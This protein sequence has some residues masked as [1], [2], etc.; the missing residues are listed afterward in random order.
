MVTLSKTTP[1]LNESALKRVKELICDPSR[2]RVAVE[3]CECG[4]TI[5]DAG[6][7]AKGGLLAGEIVAEICLTGCGTARI[8]PV[9]YGEQTLLSVF[10]AVDCPALLALDTQYKDLQDGSESFSANG[11]GPANVLAMENSELLKRLQIEE[12]S[13]VAVMALETERAP[14][15]SLIRQIA[16]KCVVSFDDLFVVIFSRNSLTGAVKASGQIVS[17]GLRRLMQAG[18]D[19][20]LVKYAWGYAPIATLHKNPAEFSERTKVAIM[21]AGVANYTVDSEDES[22]L[23][24]VLS[25]AHA[26][27]LKMFLEAKNLANQNPRYKDLLKEAGM[28]QM[29]VDV[30]A[31]APAIV[32]LSNSR[33]GLSFSRGKF[34]FEALKRAFGAI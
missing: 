34:D 10:V 17:V 3:K 20:A 18:L 33:T 19:P 12:D 32:T 6:L 7:S 28:D 13:K 14:P 29:N 27:A 11:F 25:Q 21:S 2:Y 16:Q 8:A 22:H 31:I 26:S 1:G 9:Q 23:R 30:D 24:K 5:V 15:D 4:A